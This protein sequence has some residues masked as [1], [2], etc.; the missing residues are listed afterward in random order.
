M[1]VVFGPATLHFPIIWSWRELTGCKRFGI[2]KPGF[3]SMGADGIEMLKKVGSLE[4]R[5]RES[6]IRKDRPLSWIQ[7]MHLQVLA[8]DMDER[9]VGAG[10]RDIAEDL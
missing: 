8:C 4:W 10:R 1:V 9:W 7:I 3:C 5:K 2:M 6:R